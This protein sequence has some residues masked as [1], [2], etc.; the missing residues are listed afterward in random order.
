MECEVCFREVCE[1]VE[2]DQTTATCVV[3][4][5][6][7][8]PPDRDWILCDACNKLVCNSCCRHPESGYCDSCYDRY[9]LELTLRRK[10][11]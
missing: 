10:D 5:R 3:L 9:G 8:A 11:L 7:M 1:E 4:V 6:V 2:V